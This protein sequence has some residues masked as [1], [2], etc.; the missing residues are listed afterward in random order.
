MKEMVEKMNGISDSSGKISGIIKTIEEIA[1]QTNLLALNAAVE[2][3]RAGDHGRGF[4]VVADEVRSLAQ[5]SAEAAKTTAQLIQ[6]NVQCANSATDVVKRAAEGIRKTADNASKVETNVQEIAASSKEQAKGIEQINKAVAQMD[7]V[8][9]QVAA[10]AEESASSAVQMS[11]QAQS[12]DEAVENLAMMV[13][14]SDKMAKE[15]DSHRHQMSSPQVKNRKQAKPIPQPLNAK[16]AAPT[17]ANE[18]M[19]SPEAIIPFEDDDDF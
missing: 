9:Q 5:R 15:N 8:T 6:E 3:A 16:P 13:G 19:L 1:F 17:K 4:A 11:S 18:K 14:G 7:Q 2:A 12:M 10:N